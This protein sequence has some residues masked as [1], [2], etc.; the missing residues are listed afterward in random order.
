MNSVL[1]TTRTITLPPG[2]G[3]GD[4]RIVLG[5]DLPPPLDTYAPFGGAYE[6]GI[7]FYSQGND[8]TY[9]YLCDLANT[10]AFT[11]V[12]LGHVRNGVVEEYSPG[13]PAVIL[14]NANGSG[15]PVIKDLL[16]SQFRIG[17]SIGNGIIEAPLG[18]LQLRAPTIH[19][20]GNTLLEDFATGAVATS[21]DA[22]DSPTTR[23]TSSVTYT[24]VL[25]PAAICGVAFVAPPSGKVIIT[26]GSYMDNTGAAGFTLISP[27]VREGS[28]VGAGTITVAA[29]DGRAPYMSGTDGI[30]IGRTF[31]V[32]GLTSGA[33]YNVELLQRITT[34]TGTYQHRTVTVTP[35]F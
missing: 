8:T 4:A 3:P 16:A 7:I 33:N 32:T 6:A 27:Q 20:R 23:T 10:G 11:E 17:A 5:P 12:H 35:A 29:S 9:T 21:M 31:L 34:G 14:V 19:Q 22:S 15:L 2:A 1:P 18:L 25:A 26:A 24:S 30:S 13:E 28:T